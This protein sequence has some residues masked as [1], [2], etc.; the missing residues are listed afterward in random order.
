MSGGK[1]ALVFAMGSA[2]V[3]AAAIAG[4]WEKIV[5]KIVHRSSETEPPRP[6]PDDRLASLRLTRCVAYRSLAALPMWAKATGKDWGQ[7]QMT[8]EQSRAFTLSQPDDEPLEGYNGRPDGS[9][10]PPESPV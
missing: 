8:M 10:P 4:E 5:H 2:V 3:A 1:R 9:R 7:L 6:P